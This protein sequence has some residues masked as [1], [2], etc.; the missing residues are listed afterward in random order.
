MYKKIMIDLFISAILWV[1]LPQV[2]YI[3]LDYPASGG[4]WS[5]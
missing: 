2:Q 5:H 1:E 3:A 4:F